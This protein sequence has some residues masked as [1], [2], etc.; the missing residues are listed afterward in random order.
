MPSLYEFDSLLKNLNHTSIFS[1]SAPV[2][3]T[4]LYIIRDGNVPGDARGVSRVARRSLLRSAFVV[5]PD[6]VHEVGP[7]DQAV[8]PAAALLLPPPLLVQV[9][10]VQQLRRQEGARGRHPLGDV[11]EEPLRV[12]VDEGDR[13]PVLPQAPCSSDLRGDTRV[14]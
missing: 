13:R 6:H 9:G 12:V 2:P 14:L 4:R 3:F 7:G 5:P 11:P 1:F 10:R 8:R